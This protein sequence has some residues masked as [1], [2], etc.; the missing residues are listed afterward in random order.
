MW[1]GFVI[2]AASILRLGVWPVATPEPKPMQA[3][4]LA[5]LRAQGWQLVRPIVPQRRQH[6]SNSTGYVFSNSELAKLGPAGAVEVIVVPIRARSDND[7][8]VIAMG[9]TLFGL[10]A[11]KPSLL[12]SN[13]N[14]FLTSS[15]GGQAE[16]AIACVAAGKAFTTQKALAQ[17]LSNPPPRLPDRMRAAVGLQPNRDWSCLLTTIQVR[18]GRDARS[19]IQQAWAQLQ[20]AVKTWPD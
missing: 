7:L 10:R 15:Q 11:G 17:A 9:Q 20:P 3:D 1:G 19:A 18:A 5:L 8:D 16:V 14:Q 6:L 4:H 12:R 2:T 13:G